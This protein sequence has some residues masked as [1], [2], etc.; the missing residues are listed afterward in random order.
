MHNPHLAGIIIEEKHREMRREA[1]HRLLAAQ[2]QRHRT[3][4][5]WVRL[6]GFLL[7]VVAKRL[8]LRGEQMQQRADYL[9]ELLKLS[10]EAT[11]SIQKT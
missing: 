3:T 4:I 2:I 1:E 10:A 9:T 7:T 8:I 11:A 5:V 6:Y